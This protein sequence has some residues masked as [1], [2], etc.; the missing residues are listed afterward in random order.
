[1][2][3]VRLLRDALRDNGVSLDEV[4]D[5]ADVDTWAVMWQLAG[6]E[7]L[8]PEVRKVA[9]FLLRDGKVDHMVKVINILNA[10]GE[11]KMAEAL[12]EVVN[13]WLDD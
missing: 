11:T 8:D 3:D 4:A 9:L 13:G 1:M 10:E 6:E 7:P 5:L 2:D 12:I